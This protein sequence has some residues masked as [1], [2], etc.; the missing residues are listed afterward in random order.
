V[1]KELVYDWLAKHRP[2]WQKI[3]IIA[4]NDEAGLNGAQET[5]RHI[6]D[7]GER[8]DVYIPTTKDFRMDVEKYGREEVKYNL[9]EIFN[10]I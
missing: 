9:K 8:T 4:D 6:D 1:G 10:G 5:Q 7:M 2:M 3:V